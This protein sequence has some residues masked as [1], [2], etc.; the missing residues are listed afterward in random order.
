MALMNVTLHAACLVLC[1]ALATVS[2]AMDTAPSTELKLTE[3]DNNRAVSVA[4]G[5]TVSIELEGI[6]G[7]GYSWKLQPMSS[8][9]LQHAETRPLPSEAKPGAKQTTQLIFRA[10]R[11]GESVVQL[12]YARPFEKEKPP[13][14]AFSVRIRVTPAK[15]GG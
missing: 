12:H 14:R 11:P 13:E 1:G 4:V 7:A 10:V 15:A 6:P 2:C 9:V 5:G 3:A 8:D